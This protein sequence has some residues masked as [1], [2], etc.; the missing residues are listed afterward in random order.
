MAL[1]GQ[2][3]K[4]A[5]TAPIGA[6]ATPFISGDVQTPLESVDF[7]AT[8]TAQGNFR[9]VD[10]LIRARTP[11][12]TELLERGAAE[13][14]RLQRLGLRAAVDPLEELVDDRAFEEQQA[15]LGLRGEEAQ[16]EAIAGIPVSDF[17]QELQRRQQQQL[18]RGASARGEGG[19]GASLQ[20]LSQLSGAQ[21]A[22][23]ISRRL[24]ELEAPATLQRGLRGAISQQV[25][26]EGAQ[27]A[28]IQA[29]LGTQLAN[30]RLGAAA[31]QIQ[32]LQQR[33]ELTGLRGIASARQRGQELQQ[34]AGLAG[35]LLGA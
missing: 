34:V 2:L 4:P 14:L 22:D 20:A 31:P 1:L 32:S 35:T 8:R 15:L 7:G 12:A 11:A 33:A 23:I 29:G 21:Q 13:Q 17:N 28:N 10:E 3:A 30:I 5:P 24:A 25:E 18:L 26:Q 16:R 19:G 9:D 27:R 6:N